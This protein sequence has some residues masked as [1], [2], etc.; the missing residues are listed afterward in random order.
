MGTGNPVPTVARI[1][2][3]PAHGT[4]LYQLCYPGRVTLV[5]TINSNYFPL[6]ITSE[7]ILIFRALQLF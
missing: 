4:L 3:H 5:L 7:G 1:M 2:D 6:M